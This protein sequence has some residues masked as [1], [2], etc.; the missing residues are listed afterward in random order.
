[1]IRTACHDLP[2]THIIENRITGSADT[3]RAPHARAAE[4]APAVFH[5][6]IFRKRSTQDLARPAVDAAMTPNST[7]A[8]PSSIRTH[9]RRDPTAPCCRVT[10]VD[11]ENGTP[12]HH[13]TS[14]ARMCSNTMPPGRRTTPEVPPSCDPGHPDLE[15]PPEH[16]GGR[17]ERRSND[18]FNKV[19]TPAGA[20]VVGSAIGAQLSPADTLSSK[21]RRKGTREAGG[22]QDRN[23]H[24]SSLLAEI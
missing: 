23:P 11:V 2:P 3:Q 12:L 1:M 13:Q 18:S 15:F 10:I 6:P 19:T 24:C 17:L 8:L 20:A 9:P 4:I 22:R 16:Q 7:T 5:E 14:P 21:N